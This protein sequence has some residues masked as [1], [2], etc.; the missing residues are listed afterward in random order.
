MSLVYSVE[1]YTKLC[2]HDII[3]CCSCKLFDHAMRAVLGVA[4]HY[5]HILLLIYHILLL[6]YHSRTLLSTAGL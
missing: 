4:V 2:P 3:E 5:T 6:I 1:L